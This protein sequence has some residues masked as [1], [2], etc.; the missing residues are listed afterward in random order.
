[1]ITYEV[2]ATGS[3]GNAV[4]INKEIL[5]D[6]G[7]P[8]KALGNH[9]RDL[10]LVLLTHRH[11][12][13]FNDSTIRRLATERPTLRWGVPE[14]LLGK[15]IE[16]GV[17]KQNIDIM[18][19]YYYTA[20][21]DLA[22]IKTEKTPHNVDNCA[23]H[24]YTH[25]DALFYATDTNSLDGIVARNYDLYLVE[26]NYDGVEITERIRQK[27]EAGE[28]CHEWDALNNH[29][30]KEKADD[31]LYR[32]MGPNSQYVYLHQHQ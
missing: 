13:H 12:D 1:M 24:I 29:L 7:V 15:V 30:S 25:G 22:S 19:P 4:V 3:K 20:Y 21:E 23:Y 32:N 31:W 8:F 6:C 17:K 26:A 28:Y 14:W 11:S 16:C 2:L 10:R 9:Y 5:I 18:R 27:Q